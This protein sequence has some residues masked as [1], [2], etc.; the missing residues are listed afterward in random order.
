MPG[1]SRDPL[2]AA[3]DLRNF[4]DE[5][6]RDDAVSAVD[7][8]QPYSGPH[9][10][11][12]WARGVED[13]DAIAELLD[14][15][16][17]PDE[18]VVDIGCGV[19]RLSRALSPRVGHVI[20][21]DVSAE[22]LTRA[23]E[24]N[25]HLPNVEWVQGDGET[26]E[27]VVDCTVDGC[28]SHVVFQHLPD[29]SITYGYVREMGR[30]L[31]PGGWA[32]FQVSTDPGVHLPRRTGRV[33]ALVGRGRRW[34]TDPAWLGSAV[35]MDDLRAAAHAAG[36]AVERVEREGTQFTFVRLRRLA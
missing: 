14:L 31:R 3:D 4:W 26:L 27:P 18:T 8:R 30:V 32:A 10:G 5:R 28:L 1:A 29:P 12:F 15:E 17:S 13:V 24:L 9:D 11:R 19:G 33:A 2:F 16:F 25:A 7:N 35:S 22:M 36:L 21:I 23:R 6:A 34:D 20:G